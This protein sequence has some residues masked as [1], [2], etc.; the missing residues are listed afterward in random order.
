VRAEALALALTAVLA[1]G[2]AAGDLGRTAVFTAGASLR[3]TAAAAGPASAPRVVYDSGLSAPIPDAWDTVLIQGELPDDAV[4]FQAARAGGGWVTLETHRAPDGRFW[5]KGR[6]ALASGAV[7]LRALDA[8]GRPL[9]VDVYG[10]QV[11]V[12]GS[13]E[14]AVTPGPAV[15]P[16]GPQD[17]NAP[18]P[19]VHPRAEWAAVP[20]TQPYAPDPLRWRVTLHHSDG[21][22]TR[23]LAESLAE[24]RFIQDFHIHGRGWIDIGY[25]FLVDPEGNILEGRPEGVLGAHTLGN[26]EGNIGIVLLGNYQPPHADRPTAA[27]LAAVAALGRYLVARYGIDPSMLKGHRDY[28]STDCPGDLAYAKL[29]ALR[30]AFAGVPPPPS[31]ASRPATPRAPLLTRVPSWDGRTN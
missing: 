9:S 31:L 21:R 2:A 13:G 29:D 10:V 3:F 19:L 14:A 1:S 17:P 12:S 8:S 18:R 11:F 7:R 16:H 6:L 25:H 28:K 15:P 26:N 4:V 30:K 20:P 23:T 27:Q 5:A 24:A 22:Y